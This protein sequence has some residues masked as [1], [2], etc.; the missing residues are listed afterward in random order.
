MNTLFVSQNLF[1][2]LN[3]KGQNLA[4]IGMHIISTHQKMT[5]LSSAGTLP[6]EQPRGRSTL[7]PVG[8]EWGRGVTQ[9]SMTKGNL[10]P[11]S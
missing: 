9:N 4:I 7:Q 10:H 3:V 8:C 5:H 2:M 6:R 1:N 11:F